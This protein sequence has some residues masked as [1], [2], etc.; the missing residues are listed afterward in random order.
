MENDACAL[1]TRTSIEYVPKTSTPSPNIDQLID[2]RAGNKLLSFMDAF[3]G[4]NLI[5]LAEEDQEAI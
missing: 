4:Y 5:I 3:W 1:T 2:S